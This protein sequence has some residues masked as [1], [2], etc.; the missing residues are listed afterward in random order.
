MAWRAYVPM[1]GTRDGLVSVQPIGPDLL[2]LT[3]GGTVALLNAETGETRWRARVGLP[4][5]TR[6]APAANGRTVLVVNNTFLYALSRANGQ[7]QWQY[8]LKGGVSAPLAADEESV[9][10]PGATGRLSKYYLPR[11]ELV[12][13]QAQQPKVNPLVNQL[14]EKNRR[15][16]GSI[17]HFSQSVLDA[18]EEVATGPQPVLVWEAVTGVRIETRP[19]VG[20]DRILAVGA[21]GTAVA[22]DKQ[23]TSGGRASLTYQFDADA[24]ISVPAGQF[25]DMAYIGA[26]NANLYAVNI[27]NGRVLWRHTSGQSAS[28]RP[29]ALEQ[30]VFVAAG[31]NGLARLDRAS[32]ESMWRVARGRK[33]LESNVDAERFLAANTKF[34]YAQDRLGRLMVLDRRLGHTLSVYDTRD[35]VFPVPNEITDRLYLAANNGL[36]VCLHDKEFTS[37][38]RHHRILEQALDRIRTILA[39]PI[40]DPGGNAKQVTLIET[41]EALGTKY[42]LKFSIADRAFRDLGMEPIG[43][44]LVI[45]P[46]VENKPLGEV[47]QQILTPLGATFDLVEDTIVILPGAPQPEAK[48]P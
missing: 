30:D 19:L 25:G 8:R 48:M 10:V 26:Q 15:T 23:P 24:P 39:T 28:H 34:V 32:G 42:A 9:Y 2:V 27:A 3:R 43:A 47:I 17:S 4:Y 22:F 18:G 41:L 13:L 44:K 45:F 40:T 21:E 5:R 46:K 38:I 20:H 1:D 12:A 36:I 16:T 14:Y 7:V 37:P 6:L 33:V 11:M 29:A 31:G 35:F